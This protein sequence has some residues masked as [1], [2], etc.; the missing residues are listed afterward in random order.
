[1]QTAILRESKKIL[2]RIFR[3]PYMYLPQGLMLKSWAKSFAPKKYFRELG[4]KTLAGSHVATM[5]VFVMENLSWTFRSAVK[6]INILS[7]DEVFKQ[8]SNMPL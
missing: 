6:C 7:D 1:M 3:K 8:G 4:N 2:S 5:V